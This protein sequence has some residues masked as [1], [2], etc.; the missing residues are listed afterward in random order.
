MIPADF[1]IPAQS[2]NP[3]R[4]NLHHKVTPTGDVAALPVY[5]F[6]CW[7]SALCLHLLV[8]V[9]PAGSPLTCYLVFQTMQTLLGSSRSSLNGNISF[10]RSSRVFLLNAAVVINLVS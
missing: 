1:L 6:R 9:S 3:I 10:I 4:D 2:Q 8:F 5:L 7:V